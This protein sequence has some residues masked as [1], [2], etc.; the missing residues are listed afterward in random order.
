MARVQNSIKNY[1]SNTITTIITNLLNVASRTV[2]IYILGADYL[3]I[4]GLFSNLLAMLSLAEL[5]I[6][7]AINLVCINLWLK[8]MKKKLFP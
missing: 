4:N 8:I 5:G 6:S 2:F 7:S 1:F 3:G